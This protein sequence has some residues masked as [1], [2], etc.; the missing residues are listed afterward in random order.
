MYWQG[1]LKRLFIKR[2]NA[3]TQHLDALFGVLYLRLK[4]LT[5]GFSNMHFNFLSAGTFVRM[6]RIPE[7]AMHYGDGMLNG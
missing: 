1:F 6:S 2:E 5:Q 3:S 7:T 4:R